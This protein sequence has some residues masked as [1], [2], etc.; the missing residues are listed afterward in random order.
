M[1]AL[2]G[3]RGNL[4]GGRELTFVTWPSHR[5]SARRREVQDTASALA[6]FPSFQGCD[7]DELE[8]LAAA[9]QLMTLP[10]RWTFLHEGTPADV[11]YVLLEGEVRVRL[12]QQDRAVLGAGAVLGE[13]ALL[14]GS[15]RTASVVTSSAVRALRVEYAAL[16]A[17]FHLYPQ[18]LRSVTTEFDAID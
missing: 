3:R 9:G 15:L 14:Q 2:I 10:A 16:S 13:R 18:L 4:R 11:C 1:Q 17:L 7:R 12:G 6:A 8:A 5:P